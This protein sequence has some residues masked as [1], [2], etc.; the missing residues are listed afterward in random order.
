MPK[1]IEIGQG[2][3]ARLRKVFDLTDTG[4][5]EDIG[6]SQDAFMQFKPQ[7]EVWEKFARDA[8]EWLLAQGFP[9]PADHYLRLDLY[10]ADGEDSL[11]F[12]LASWLFEFRRV[13]I[14]GEQ[15]KES[16]A[17][18]SM[19][20]FAVCAVSLGRLEGR[21]EALNR[22]D[23]KTGKRWEKLALSGQQRSFQGAEG[24]KMNTKKSFA[25]KHG[26]AA[27]LKANQLHAERPT[28]TWTYI[29][30]KIAD[31]FGVKPITVKRNLENP[32]TKVGSSA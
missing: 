29:V 14:F 13:K 27:Q 18:L 3:S 4:P 8:R 6:L 2:T 5:E 16:G 28:R 30:S 7:I 12:F 20:E 31:E 23:P 17:R 1:T 9:D 11:A 10:A 22:R 25:V 24:R 32:K 26:E 21:F 19:Q 15:V